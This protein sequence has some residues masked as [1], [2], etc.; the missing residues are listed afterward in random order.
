LPVTRT[1]DRGLTVLELLAGNPSLGISEI[2]RRLRMSPSTVSRLMTTLVERD[3]V[4]QDEDGT[5]YRIGV[6]AFEVGVAFSRQRRLDQIAAPVLKHFAN[7]MGDTVNLSIRAG[8]DIIYIGQ[9]EGRGLA[10]AAMPIG[11]RR[12]L[13]CTAAG[14]VILA[15]LWEERVRE[16]VGPA[17]LAQFTEKTIATVEDLLD[18]LEQV[19]RRGYAFDDQEAEQGVCCIA[20][21]IRADSEQVIA[22]VS[23]SA[24]VN[25]MPPERVETLGPELVRVGQEISARLGWRSPDRAA[26]QRFDAPGI[27]M[28]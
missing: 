26:G 7:A 23:V 11:W 14:K 12:P 5:G 10:R 27:F 15:W 16:L 2:A 24:L 21:P 1:L 6:R 8:S 17:P 22:S 3:F 25:Q 13:H 20:A 4:S 9:F 19:R 28:D 18:D